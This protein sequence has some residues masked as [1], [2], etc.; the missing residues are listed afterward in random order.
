M[1]Y[2]HSLII[3]LMEYKSSF[4]FILASTAKDITQLRKTG[5]DQGP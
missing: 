3:S 5:I 1:K 2:K 4:V